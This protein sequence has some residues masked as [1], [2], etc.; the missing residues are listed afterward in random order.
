MLLRGASGALAAPGRRRGWGG[1]LGAPAAGR[2]A[3]V[4]PRLSAR[5]L[6]FPCC[7]GGEEGGSRAPRPASPR[8]AA[9]SCPRGGARRGTAASPHLL[10]PASRIC[11][12]AGPGGLAGPGVAWAGCR[13][14]G[15]GPRRRA[16]AVP[17]PVGAGQGAPTRGRGMRD[18][19]APPS[20][21][22]RLAG[23][24]RP[25]LLLARRLPPLRR[26]LPKRAWTPQ[27]QGRTP[28]YPQSPRDGLPPDEQTGFGGGGWR[29]VPP[30]HASPA[31]T[32]IW[33]CLMVRVC[34]ATS[35]GVKH[36]AAGTLWSSLML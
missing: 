24:L 9:W 19:A 15:A 6:P 29:S 27:G 2:G 7:G 14:W 36:L 1:L 32:A 3:A 8:G 12:P 21:W 22:Q 25:R 20:P 33:R 16:R 34:R 13:G 18:A 10:T 23:P 28:A 30:P 17:A 5:G 31:G 4:L 35:A 26:Q 11:G